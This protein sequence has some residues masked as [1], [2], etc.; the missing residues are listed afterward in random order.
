MSDKADKSKRDDNND[1]R[2][3]FPLPLSALHK[4]A[5]GRSTTQACEQQGCPAHGEKQGIVGARSLLFHYW[6]GWRSASHCRRSTSS[7]SRW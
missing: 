3:V 4:S 1:N 7:G 2:P 5:S 6:R